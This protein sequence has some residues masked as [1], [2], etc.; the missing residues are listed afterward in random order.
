VLERVG[1]SKAFIG[2]SFD[3]ASS[4][5]PLRVSGTTGRPV[6][7]EDW[8]RRLE[9]ALIRPLAPRNLG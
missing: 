3:E 5:V 7:S 4:Y 9:N 1:P 2:E 6:G 8:I